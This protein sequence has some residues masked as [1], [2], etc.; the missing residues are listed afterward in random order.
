[1]LSG[2][3]D[4][5]FGARTLIKSPGF[6]VIAILVIALGVGANSAIF[7]VFNAVLLQPLPFPDPDRLVVSWE[8]MPNTKE[9]MFISFPGFLDWRSQ[10]QG[11]EGMA[12][13]SGYAG[14]LT[15]V[16]PPLRLTGRMVSAGFFGILGVTLILGR[17]IGPEEDKPDAAP[18]AVISYRL[19]AIPL[20]WRSAHHRAEGGAR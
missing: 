15:G 7:S 20:W 2:L 14:T 11:F 5:R 6:S 8:L 3:P 4:L 13:Y 18:V 9:R 17:S 16:D 12:G 1:M 10:A 19:L